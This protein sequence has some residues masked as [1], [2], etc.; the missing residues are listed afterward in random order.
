MS[1][2]LTP[3]AGLLVMAGALLALLGLSS[4]MAKRVFPS[5]SRRWDNHPALQGMLLLAVA[6]LWLPLAAV[7][8]GAGAAFIT[9]VVAGGAVLSLWPGRQAPCDCFGALTPR[10]PALHLCLLVLAL[11]LDFVI[12]RERDLL[13]SGLVRW[14]TP[15]VGAVL[16][17]G[18][19]LWLRLRRYQTAFYRPEKLEGQLPE[20]L[21]GDRVLGHTPQGQ[22]RTVA[23]LI[24][25]APGLVVVALSSSCVSCHTLLARLSE[26]ATASPDPLP[27]AVVSDHAR[28]FARD[29]QGLVTLVDPQV[30]IARHLLAE[31]LPLGFAVDDNFELLAPPSSGNASILGLLALLDSIRTS[32]VATVP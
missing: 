23:E 15:L 17:A 14:L 13:D 8:K 29:V 7:A 32:D 27:I 30:A 24:G 3:G 20:R 1:M 16:A 19:Y 2:P 6:L 21:E 10:G 18:F 26:H 11:L 31:K 4:V 22:A 12:W 9:A 25:H 5:G 28:M